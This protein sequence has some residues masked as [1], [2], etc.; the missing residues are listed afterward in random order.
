[1]RVPKVERMNTV[2]EEDS[3]PSKR[4]SKV[5][6]IEEYNHR[7]VEHEERSDSNLSFGLRNRANT[8]HQK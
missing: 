4:Q 5:M 1:M 3:C 7:E 8:F 6:E 2:E